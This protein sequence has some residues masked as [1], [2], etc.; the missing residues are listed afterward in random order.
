MGMQRDSSRSGGKLFIVVRHRRDPEQPFTAVW[1]D[2]E[3]LEGMTTSAEIGLLCAEAR[4][5]R[6]RT[7]VH[8]CG[9]AETGPVICCSA[10]VIRSGPIEDGKTHWVRFVEHEVL[11]A[12]PSLIVKPGQGFYFA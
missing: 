8:R 6:E 5:K 12:V 4:R 3:R 11:D 1:L 9:W 2:D 10:S 7:Y